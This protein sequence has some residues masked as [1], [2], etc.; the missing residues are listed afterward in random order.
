[1]PESNRLPPP[2]RPDSSPRRRGHSATAVA[3]EP[4]APSRPGTAV[5][6]PRDTAGWPGGTR[7]TARRQRTGC[8]LLGA[9]AIASVV[10]VLALWAYNQGIQSLSLGLAGSDS[11]GRLAGLLASDL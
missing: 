7:R 6:T 5:D 1:M 11:F 2:D 3:A 8:D 9:L 4:A 10:V